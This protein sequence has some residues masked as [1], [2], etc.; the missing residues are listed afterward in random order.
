MLPPIS[1]SIEASQPLLSPNDLTIIDKWGLVG[2]VSFYQSKTT[3][4]VTSSKRKQNFPP[5]L[6]NGDELDNSTSLTQPGLS[7]SSN[8]TWKSHIH[9]S[10]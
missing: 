8:L 1:Y 3:Q 7:L 5:V 6:M 4:A 2:L 9:S 10:S